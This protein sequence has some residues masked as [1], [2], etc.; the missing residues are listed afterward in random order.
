MSHIHRALY[1][2]MELTEADD[3]DN[4]NE[5]ALSIVRLLCEEFR[6]KEKI[7]NMLWLVKIP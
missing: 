7:K 5:P 2:L 6:E 1:P 3:Y 4:G